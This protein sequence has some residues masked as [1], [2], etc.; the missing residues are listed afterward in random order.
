MRI[1]HLLVVTA[2]L[3]SAGCQTVTVK[4]PGT[5]DMRSDGAGAPAASGGKPLDAKMA[6]TGFDAI[7]W[8]DGVSVSGPH[9]TVKDRRYWALRL[10]PIA[11]ESATEEIA[12]AVGDNGAVKK[13]KIGDGYDLYSFGIRYVGRLVTSVVL[14]SWA[15]ELF[16]PPWTATFE[17]DRIS[18][19]ASSAPDDT[20]F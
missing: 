3:L 11:N 10:V 16:M 5:L 13:V 4:V 8:G 15:Y 9:V 1:V 2:V 12:A 6:R 17:G 7:I 18:T 19:G 20:V 14:L